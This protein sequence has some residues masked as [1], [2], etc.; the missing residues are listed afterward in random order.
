MFVATL[1]LL[2]NSYYGYNKIQFAEKTEKKT[3]F[4]PIKLVSPRF[5]IVRFFVEEPIEKKINELIE[6]S[7]PLNK[8]LLL[9]YPEGI[10]NIGELK[11]D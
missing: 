5:N 7:Y 10:T 6:I 3:I 9:I 8:D 4:P 2:F 11:F 1:I